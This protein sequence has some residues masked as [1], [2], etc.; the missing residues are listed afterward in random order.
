MS[1]EFSKI[2]NNLINIFKKITPKSIK[3][4][5]VII[6]NIFKMV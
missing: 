5:Y 6:Y 3:V 1:E 4:E 2:G